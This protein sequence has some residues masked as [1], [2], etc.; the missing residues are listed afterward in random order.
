MRRVEAGVHR[1][2]QA[3]DH[4]RIGPLGGMVLMTLAETSGLPMQALAE[5]TGRDK[6]QIT[7][8]VQMLE[9]KAAI[10]KRSCP[11]DRRVTL[12]WLTAKG[13]SMAE[14]LSRI[15]GT[16]VAEILADLEESD[17]DVLVRVLSQF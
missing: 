7:R 4:D 2:A 10:E 15:T 5:R 17:R 9:A 3:I 12:L 13:C 16:V 6:S 14:D 1:R 8:L 11:T